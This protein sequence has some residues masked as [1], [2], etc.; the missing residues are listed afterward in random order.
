MI[1]TDP[2]CR[3]APKSASQELV[4]PEGNSGWSR[5]VQPLP[6]FVQQQISEVMSNKRSRDTSA[7]LVKDIRTSVSDDRREDVEKRTRYIK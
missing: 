5:A 3:Q 1:C 6:G 2:G 7:A 4:A